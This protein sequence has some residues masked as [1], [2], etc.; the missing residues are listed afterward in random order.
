MPSNKQIA[1]DVLE[2]VGGKDNVSNVTH[3]MTRLRF[4]LK[5]AGFPDTKAVKNIHGVLGVQVSGGQYQVIIG[6]NV[7]KVYDEVC[8]LG[9]F[10]K[11]AAIDENLDAP[12][13]KLTPK[14]IG[15][16]IL[17]YLSGSMVQIIPIIMCGGLFRTVAVVL[18]P[19]MFGILGD[20]D[21][22]YTL[23]YT[24]LYNASFYF[25]PVSLGY[26]AAKKIG[27]TPVLGLLMGCILI[28]PDIVTAAAN[29]EMLSVYGISI[30]AA[31]Y[32]QSVLPILLSIP[33]LYAV[34]K[35]VK[36][37]MP[38]VLSTI[39]T[40]FVTM[41]I[42]VPISLIVLA[43]IGSELGSLLSGIVFAFSDAN[44]FVRVIA[45]MV[46][47][48]LWQF[49]VIS[50]MHIAIVM[51]ALTQLLETG[52][53]PFLFV[54]TN[55]AQF[56]VFGVALGAFLRIRNKE[57]KALSL[58][59]F[60]SGFVGGV[61]EPALFGLVLRFKRCML[62]LMAGGAAG[63]LVAALLGVTMYASGGA[64]NILVLMRYLPGGTANLVSTVVAYGI[65][66]VVAAAVTFFFGFGKEDA[67]VIDRA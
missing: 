26:T 17:N 14:V 59:Y 65:A 7:P 47:G 37:V 39:F 32:S 31:N 54:S 61:T 13:E 27:A 53:D 51:L 42:M 11:Q 15:N 5:D 16:K 58:G 34:E 56:A 6:Q 2:A 40:P 41:A 36:R 63:A 23:F 25:L 30:P 67:E 8:A 28:S 45:M 38:D 9:G 35:A 44:V 29:G 46:I 10:A 24:T 20:T 22:L 1:Q 19:Q 57:E 4:S 50:G 43:P 48:A 21:P 18:G 64:S 66:L 3:C 60:V 62:G 49:V 52:T 55:A 12:K 33:V